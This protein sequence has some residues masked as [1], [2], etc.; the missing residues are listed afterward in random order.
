M[1]K[2]R[3]GEMIRLYAFIYEIRAEDLA[4]TL[5]VSHATVCRWLNGS[6]H[7]PLNAD[8][9]RWILEPHTPPKKD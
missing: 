8:I 4:K 5:D 9:V 1:K 7:P 3:L 6:N 2:S